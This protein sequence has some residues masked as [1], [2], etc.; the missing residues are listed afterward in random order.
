L[1]L[2]KDSEALD[3]Y[4]KAAEFKANEFTTPFYLQRAGE[5]AEKT[6]QKEKALEYYERIQREYPQSTE[7]QS[8]D[9][10]LT[11]VRLKS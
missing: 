10:Y 1:Q 5:I 3:C 9:R 6:G 8:I 4:L 11:R 2:K 7:G